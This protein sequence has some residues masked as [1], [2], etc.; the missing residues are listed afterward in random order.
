MLKL[1]WLKAPFARKSASGIFFGI[2]F[3]VLLERASENFWPLVL[4]ESARIYGE[5]EA[6]V[7]ALVYWPKVSRKPQQTAKIFST[8]KQN[9]KYFAMWTKLSL[10]LLYAG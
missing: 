10:S 2:Y 4:L 3:S 7:F 5:R 1:L 9:L 8:R 6:Q